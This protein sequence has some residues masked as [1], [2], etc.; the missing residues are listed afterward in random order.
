MHFYDRQPS[1]NWEVL[2]L[3][4]D[5]HLGLWTWFKPPAAPL[6]VMIQIPV[7]THRAVTRRTPLTL[8]SLLHACG[9][10]PAVVGAV[11]VYGVPVSV[12]VPAGLLDQSLPEPPQNADPS[13][14]FHVHPWAASAYAPT[15][16]GWP[17][18]GFAA[19]PPMTQNLT[20]GGVG[21]AGESADDLFLRIAGDWNA[22]LQLEQQIDA[23]A[24]QLNGV[25]ARLNGLNRDLS[26]EEA[27]FADQ[28]D[29]REWQDARRWMRDA[30][31][32]VSRLLKE[33]L[34][35]VS[36][37]AG[38]RDSYAAIYEQFVQSRR[39]FEGMA[40]A[41][42]DFAGYRKLLQTLLNSMNSAHGSAVQD[43]ERRGQALVARMAARIRN[44][45]TK[46]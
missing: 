38:K 13:I 23:A 44:S 32:K 30:S 19:S 14:A 46:R 18:P 29:K 9:V 1:A 7:E 35:G 17:L 11:T 26:P 42:R 20:A 24:K 6:G 16:A 31:A 21:Q 34:V 4:A 22:C 43:A 3:P 41:D 2:P 8:R 28:Q 33:H 40:Q 10:E 15:A 36:S 25:L 45:K 37:M 39:P 5:P 27:R 12:H